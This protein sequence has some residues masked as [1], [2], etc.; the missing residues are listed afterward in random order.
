MSKKKVIIVLG[1]HR[2]GTSALTRG[3]GALGIN[4]GDTLYP[5]ADDNPTGFWEDRD[6]ISINDRL[7]AQLGSSY[8]RVGLVDANLENSAE[9]ELIFHEAKAVISGKLA[10][11]SVWGVKDPRIPRLLPFWKRLF[12]ELDCELGYVIAL[13]NPLSV[14]DSLAFRNQFA[15]IKSYWL[16]LEHTLQA[17]HYTAGERRL[18]VSYDRMLAE[19]VQELSRMAEV[20]RL[21]SPEPEA[22]KAYVDGFLDTG[23]R[24]SSRTEAELQQT[25]VELPL[26]VM[27]YDL[28]NQCASESV[29]VNS[30]AF[31]ERLT[32]LMAQLRIFGP[33]LKLVADAEGAAEAAE[34][35]FEGIKED[36][37][38]LGRRHNQLRKIVEEGKTGYEALL[39]QKRNLD[40]SLEEFQRAAALAQSLH[41]SL[42]LEND[43]IA[44]E[45]RHSIE[46][47]ERTAAQL[48]VS[49]GAWASFFA[50]RA[51]RMLSM[52][53]ER[54]S[55]PAVTLQD[56]QL[57]DAEYYLEANPDVR[58]AQIPALV[59]F[60]TQGLREGRL[61]VLPTPVAAQ[62]STDELDTPIVV[63]GAE[64]ES[65]ADQAEIAGVGKEF[66]GEFDAEFYLRIYPDIAMA[67]IDPLHHYLNHGR[68]EGRLGA[69]PT[70]A[71]SR[72]L[73][74]L[75][76]DRPTV[77]VVS[78]E[79][80]RTGAPI[81]SLNIAQQLLK[82]YNVV[83]LLFGGGS[84][85][86]AFSDAGAVVAGPIDRSHAVSAQLAIARLLDAHPFAFAIVNSLESHVALKPLAEH[87]VPSVSL[88]HEFAIYTRPLAAVHKALL[89]A[90]ETVFSA[91]ATLDSARLAMPE[92]ES[93]ALPVLP[94]GKSNVPGQEVDE[95]LYQDEID[96]LRRELRPAGDAAGTI[97]ILGAG[98]VQLRKGV[99]LFIECATRVLASDI[100]A[101]CRFVWIGDNYN[102]E[103]DIA[104]SVY[105]QD[106]IQRAGIADRFAIISETAAIEQVYALSDMLV[107][108]SRL[109]PLPNVAIDAMTAGLPVLCFDRTTGI[110]DVLKRNDLGEE[111]VAQY[112]D[113]H[114][115]AVKVIQ[116][117][118]DAQ[119]LA[120]VGGKARAAAAREF[121]MEHYVGKLV[122][123]A[124]QGAAAQATER[125]DAAIL[126]ESGVMDEGFWINPGDDRSAAAL[127]V[128]KYI[129]S[130]S[131]GV[132]RRKALP[133]FNPAIYQALNAE[134]VGSR[135]PLAHYIQASRPQGAWNWP[136]FDLAAHADSAT[137]NNALLFVTVTSGQQLIS[138][139]KQ[140]IDA[141]AD[142]EVVAIVGDVPLKRDVERVL[143]DELFSPITVLVGRNRSLA[144]LLEHLGSRR[145]KGYAAI[146]HVDL[147]RLPVEDELATLDNYRGYVIQNM[148]C[149]QVP[150]VRAIVAAIL[151]ADHDHNL[152]LVFPE[153]P[154]VVDLEGDLQLLHELCDALRFKRSATIHSP[155]PVNGVF[156]AAPAALAR[157]VAGRDIWTS[158]FTTQ[159]ADD[160]EQERLLARLL[161]QSC[162]STG[163]AFASTVVPGVTY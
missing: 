132:L 111:C 12:A 60:L 7:L 94:Q 154:Y 43:A 25:V 30:T 127:L 133:G 109:D 92:L 20:L 160:V 137:V 114:D 153:S 59:H 9:V 3:L 120:R 82:Q 126:L 45:L 142:I 129:R 77:L 125:A 44:R 22:L 56:G 123:V 14:A 105:L 26:L 87:F 74:T 96:R 113:T 10:N 8:D 42:R 32:P 54:K 47:R 33:T 69:V 58:D 157:L 128:R 143:A 1:M 150:A 67:G 27:A 36:F 141:G 73:S 97:V 31:E 138:V 147:A 134:A 93:C 4:L 65:P 50:S 24:H 159:R 148:I 39:D 89:W 15:P 161:T 28:I 48:S 63:L 112:L 64:V 100:G 90:G 110:A 130:W 37:A 136:T 156:W 85:V 72:A 102:P 78:H 66:A 152:G 75:P 98:R 122:A 76:D 79:A 70:V 6:V 149:G 155:Y 131:R 19:P 108:S 21:P 46:L 158:V 83:A 55:L 135:D 40:S 88:I 61:G 11:T 162:V 18:V 38:E 57:F 35:N 91:Q 163:K 51:W 29:D 101:K 145:Y 5:A 13:R 151:A 99:E 2:S 62:S 71:L 140:V 49:S 17:L 121:N 23:L 86:E 16:W 116:L 41:E 80:S 119:A 84:L 144:T 68:H 95:D 104:Y 34:H 117:A 115:L 107:I 118:G 124:E 139:V 146:G 81:L 53:G 106:Q 52:V 103:Q